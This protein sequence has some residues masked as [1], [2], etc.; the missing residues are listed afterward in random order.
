M[1]PFIRELVESVLRRGC[2][3]VA[4]QEVTRD[5]RVFPDARFTQASG[6]EALYR[7]SDI[8]AAHNQID[9]NHVAGDDVAQIVAYSI[10]KRKT[11]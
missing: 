5:A 4:A 8:V 9:R 11:T 6:N 7:V 10:G 2:G 1:H 3:T